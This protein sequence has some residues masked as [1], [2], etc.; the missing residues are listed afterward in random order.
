MQ[1]HEED[2]FDNENNNAEYNHYDKIYKIPEN[3][4]CGDMGTIYFQDYNQKN[5]EKDYNNN[6]SYNNQ[7]F[8]QIEE[9]M[10][11]QS[12]NNYSN[13]INFQGELF[14]QNYLKMDNH[15]ENLISLEHQ[16]FADAGVFQMLAPENHKSNGN[17]SDKV[18]KMQKRKKRLAENDPR[19]FEDL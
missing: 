18:F 5:S 3:S 12:Y 17:S 15:T 13:Q 6:N 9:N 7:S 14:S 16:R 19:R 4:G 11:Q 10:Q 8:Y 2:R 1:S